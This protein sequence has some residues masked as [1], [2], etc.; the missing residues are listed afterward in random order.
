MKERIMGFGSKIKRA[1]KNPEKAIKGTYHKIDQSAGKAIFGNT[2]GMKH[3][4]NGTINLLKNNQFNVKSHDPVIQQFRTNGY[5]KLNFN[6]D[7][8]LI[9]KI[10][11]KYE[12]MIEDDRFSFG[13]GQHDGKYHKRQIIDAHLNILELSALIT[14]DVIEIVK[15]YY[16]SNFQ[17]VRIDL[18][19]TY[20]IS[21]EI[22]DKDLISNRWHCDNRKTDRLKLFI[23]MAKVTENDGP[24]HLQSIPRTKDLM[25]LNFGHREDYGVPM[26]VIEDP[27]YVVKFIGPP[28]S[29]VFANTTTCLHR[30]GNPQTTRDIIQFL[31]R[32][33]RDPLSP[34]W[35]KEVMHVGPDMINT[36]E[37]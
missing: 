20:H 32:S 1:I 37:E 8:S 15:Q 16:G 2:V 6:Y 9:D 31:F 26:E 22:M 27:K 11:T 34:N 24:F 7:K 14:D 30:A 21:Q 5:M 25:K 17:V 33:S 28:G 18:W 13:S 12:K 10:R 4:L 19:R 35:F 23:N 36:T 29:A 3:N